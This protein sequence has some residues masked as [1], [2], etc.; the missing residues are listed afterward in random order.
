[1]FADF[2]MAES[3][4]FISILEPPGSLNHRVDAGSTPPQLPH[5]NNTP[6]HCQLLAQE[7]NYLPPPETIL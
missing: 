1:M 7:Q 4:D 5:K 6:R 3:L 2:F